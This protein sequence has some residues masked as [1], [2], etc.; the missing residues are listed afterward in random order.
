MLISSHMRSMKFSAAMPLALLVGAC[1]STPEPLIGPVTA[2][3]NA[4][5]GQA[6]Y[7]SATSE[8][9]ALNAGDRL[10]VLVF[11]EP[12]LSAEAIAISPEGTIALP[13]IGNVQAASLTTDQLAQDIKGRLDSAGLRQPDV[14][15]NVVEFASHLV[16]VEG[17]VEEPG[18]YQFT[19]GA[20]LSSAIALAKGPNRVA[21]LR[22]V[23]V[24]REVNEQ[25][26]I[27][28]FDYQA[29]RRGTMI[30]PVM[31]PGDR[32]VVGISGLSQLWQDTIRALPAFGLFTQI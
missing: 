30:D 9:Y 31:Q 18:V 20:K 25:V 7:Q 4:D 14:S 19:P 5:L 24:F 22:E 26:S 21:K 32:V 3:A 12:D 10:S 13:L 11:R 6:D 16:T 1:A 29:V 17:G 23:V 27:A 8:A 2:T 28:K 15:V